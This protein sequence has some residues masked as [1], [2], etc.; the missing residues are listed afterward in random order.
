MP[1]PV[2]LLQSLRKLRQALDK[3]VSELEAAQPGIPESQSTL[4]PLDVPT[5]HPAAKAVQLQG[6]YE[7]AKAD[8]DAQIL[9]GWASVAVTK[10]G[11]EV[12]DAH[13]DV[14]AIEDLENAAYD[15]VLKS[16]ASGEDHAGQT[17]GEVVES[18]V[19]TEEKLEALGLAKGALPLGWWIG[20]HIP[21]RESFE[22]AKTAK[23]MFSIEGTAVREEV[24]A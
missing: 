15:F 11:D 7:V 10:E 21:D 1:S 2:T 18:I 5:L 16:R 9:F 4:A 14:I 8:D 13:D 6:S 20:V 19:F 12:V 3:V 22:R 23:Q 24:T 17:D